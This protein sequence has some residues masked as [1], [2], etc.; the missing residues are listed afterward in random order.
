M[1]PV[2]SSDVTSADS[3][4]LHFDEYLAMSWFRY[5]NFLKYYCTVTGQIGCHHCIL[6]SDFNFMTQIYK[7]ILKRFNVFADI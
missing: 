7:I 1:F 6:H 5:L 3:G 2:D 4:R